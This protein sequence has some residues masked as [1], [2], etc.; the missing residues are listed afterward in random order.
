[1]YCI[2]S[3]TTVTHWNM[4]GVCGLA[5]EIRVLLSLVLFILVNSVTSQDV[6]KFP[7][8]FNAAR[9]RPLVTVPTQ[10]VCGVPTRSAFCRSSILASSLF[11]CRQNYCV[12]DCPRR[13]SLPAHVD[14]L[15]GTGFN[16][17]VTT[18]SVNIRPGS[19]RPEFSVFFGQGTSCF[20]SPL[21]T[22]VVGPSGAFTLT[23]WIWQETGNIG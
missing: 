2:C 10:S 12:Q 13:T 21:T 16:Q 4:E 1:M 20:I 23:F 7:P 15:E 11:E 18:D 19:V 8:L 6:R 14:L 3:H 9:D 5:E 22:P 17:C